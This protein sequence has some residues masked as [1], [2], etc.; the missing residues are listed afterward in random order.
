MTT[1]SQQQLHT[2]GHLGRP[3]VCEIRSTCVDQ[4]PSASNG[5][6]VLS[7]DGW[8]HTFLNFPIKLK[9]LA[10]E[11]QSVFYLKLYPELVSV[12]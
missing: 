4:S 5:I 11:F 8:D 12:L 10:L 1:K 9:L 6:N 2:H 3:V 7:M